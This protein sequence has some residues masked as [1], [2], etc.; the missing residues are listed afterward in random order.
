MNVARPLEVDEPKQIYWLNDYQY[1]AHDIHK[2]D[3]T[4]SFRFAAG[5]TVTVTM[6]DGNDHQIA[7]WTKSYFNDVPP[8]DKAP[9]LGQ[10][11]RL[12]VVSLAVTP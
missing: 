9:S 4:F 3:Y 11:L 7:N 8:Y 1:L 10:S 5:A 6:N 2:E 12:D